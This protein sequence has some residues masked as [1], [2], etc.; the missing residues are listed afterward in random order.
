VIRGGS[1]NNEPRNVRS[2]N[3]NRNTPDNR[4]N[5]VGFRLAQSI[6]TRCVVAQSHAAYGPHG[7]G[8]RMSM[9]PFPGLLRRGAPNSDVT[10]GAA[11]GR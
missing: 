11:R 3:R 2:A 5:N 8:V 7:R 4:N 10:D 9:S 6:R 1:W